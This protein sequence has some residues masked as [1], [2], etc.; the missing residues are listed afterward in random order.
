[1]V[2]EEKGQDRLDQEEK[3]LDLV[4]QGVKDQDLV[5]QGEKDQDLEDQG[6]R[7]QDQ[8]VLVVQELVLVVQVGQ[9]KDQED[10]E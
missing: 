8:V 7:D 9:E 2:L 10:L 5:D 1:V 6:E 3:D 4:V